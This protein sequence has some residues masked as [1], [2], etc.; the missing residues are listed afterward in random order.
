MACSRRKVAKAKKLTDDELGG[1]AIAIADYTN[2][3]LIKLFLGNGFAR[4]LMGKD[5]M[6][7]Q[8]HD[9]IMEEMT[10]RGLK[11]EGELH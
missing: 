5:T 3:K 7:G 10:R 8:M 6:W 11:A 2:E 9:V 4:A 1:F